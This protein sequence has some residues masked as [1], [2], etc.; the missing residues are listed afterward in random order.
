MP[1]YPAR[2]AL[3]ENVLPLSILLVEDNPVSQRVAARILGN[4]GYSVT[5]EDLG[6]R[7]WAHDL[8]TVGRDDGRPN[9]GGKPAQ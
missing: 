8:R 3:A 5:R 2:R 1:T 9:L 6:A 7:D 4:Q